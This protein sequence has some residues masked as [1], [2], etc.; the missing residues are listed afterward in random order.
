MSLETR[1]S[2]KEILCYKAKTGLPLKILLRFAGVSQRTWRE[3]AQR[4]GIETKHNNNIPRNYYLTPQE[5]ASIALY[6]NSERLH[7]AV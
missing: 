7:S 4:R 1:R 3:W 5:I 2:G 6:Y